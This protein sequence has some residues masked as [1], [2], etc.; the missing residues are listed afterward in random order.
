MLSSTLFSSPRGGFAVLFLALCS[1]LG[2]SLES[3]EIE[4]DPIVATGQRDDVLRIYLQSSEDEL[5]ELA[6][7]AF[8]VHGGFRVLSSPEEAQFIFQFRTSG[9]NEVSGRVLS[10]RPP[11]ELRRVVQR[12]SSSR[13][14]LLRTADEMV[15]LTTRNPGF[16]A[17]RLTFV[18]ERGEGREVFTSD[19][20][21]GE[22]RQ[23]T[24]D[25]SD[26]VGP[27]WSPDGRRIVYTSYF[28][29]GFP[30][31]F[32]IDLGTRRREATVTL[33]GTNTGA[34]FSPDGRNLVMTLTGEG[35]SEVYVSN[36]RGRNIRRL[37]RT[38]SV[39]SSPGWSPDGRQI[40]FASDRM[41]SP[42]LYVMN[43]DGS[44][45][46]RLPTDI[47]RYAA[48][49]DWNP[50]D[51]NKIAFTAAVAGRFALAVYDQEARESRFITRG[52]ADAVHPRWLA[53]GRHIVFTERTSNSKVLSIVDTQVREGQS[54][55][56]TPLHRSSQG[57]LSM[58][59]AILLP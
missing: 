45:V 42:Q 32:M 4:L 34:R 28:Q 5:L 12:G 44:G 40:I 22:V 13:N 31:I 19:L 18:G 7:R 15:R 51:T 29:S 38:N 8:S 57:K 10:G 14:A 36:I 55:K 30:D 17:S 16:F 11:E 53:D 3:R 58:P 43:R 39:Q 37:T 25:G 26:S 21:L 48:E 35:N 20:F 2:P 54:P 6:R 56:V 1:F 27:R 33:D 59:D 46:R 9:A 24:R 23:L 50:V 52:P 49:P 47:S 41:G